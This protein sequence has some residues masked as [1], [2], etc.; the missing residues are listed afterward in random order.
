MGNIR[1]LWKHLQK[2]WEN[3]YF[4]AILILGDRQYSQSFFDDK[5]SNNVSSEIAI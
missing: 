4:V 3:I 1:D 5:D 2:Y